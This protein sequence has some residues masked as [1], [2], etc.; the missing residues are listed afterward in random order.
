[1]VAS[2]AAFMNGGTVEIN[3]LNPEIDYVNGTVST[4]VEAEG[5]L[6]GQ[7]AGLVENSAFLDFTLGADTSSAF[8][9]LDLVR[10]FPDVALTFN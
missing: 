6:T 5:T 2:G 3:L 1:M 7:F 8:L 10:M 9:T 4:K